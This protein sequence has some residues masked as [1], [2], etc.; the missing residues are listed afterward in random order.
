MVVSPL[1]RDSVPH[2]IDGPLVPVHGVELSPEAYDR[3][4][5]WKARLRRERPGM[6]VSMSDVLEDLILCHPL[7]L[8]E[9]IRRPVPVGL[10]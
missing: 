6:H 2:G 9:R 5:A 4:Q 8:P 10:C 7:L 1:F 3:L